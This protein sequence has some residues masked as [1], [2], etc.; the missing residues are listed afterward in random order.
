MFFHVLSRFSMVFPMSFSD[1]PGAF[2]VH[3]PH[4]EDVPMLGRHEGRLQDVADGHAAVARGDEAA[5]LTK[6]ME[7]Y[8]GNIM[9]LIL[10]C[11][12]FYI[13]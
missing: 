7:E 11:N 1:A 12:V 8:R 3:R 10:Y 4:V 9:V 2:Q 5:V 6:R 13:L